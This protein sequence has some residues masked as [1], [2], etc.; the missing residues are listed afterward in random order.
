MTK[1][2]EWQLYVVK[3]FLIKM[4]KWYIIENNKNYNDI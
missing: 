4:D 2:M 3:V 1:I